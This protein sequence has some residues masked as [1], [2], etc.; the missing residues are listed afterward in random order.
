VDLAIAELSSQQAQEAK[1]DL[2]R[3]IG[4][5]SFRAIT[6]FLP[7]RNCGDDAAV[8]ATDGAIFSSDDDLLVDGVHFDRTT[9]QKTLVGDLPAN[10]SDLAAMGATPGITVGLGLCG[11]V[12]VSWV[13][14]LYRE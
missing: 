6:A 4:E 13:E 10:L 2:L 5:K 3:D 12:P 1:S 11:D 14:R 9:S 7:T 8:L